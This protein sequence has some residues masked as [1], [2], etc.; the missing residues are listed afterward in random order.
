MCKLRNLVKTHQ[1]GTDGG[2]KEEVRRLNKFLD[3]L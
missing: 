2:E 1:M 3:Q